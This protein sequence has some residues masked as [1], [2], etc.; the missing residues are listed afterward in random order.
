MLLPTCWCKALSKTGYQEVLF[1]SNLGVPCINPKRKSVVFN[2]SS[3]TTLTKAPLQNWS[4][5]EM[6]LGAVRKGRRA[7]NLNRGWKGQRRE[8]QRHG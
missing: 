1:S 8:R 5:S 2:L 7:P 4:Q 6:R 3:V